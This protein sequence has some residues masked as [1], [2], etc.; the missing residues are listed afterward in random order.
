MFKT[1]NSINALN[2]RY[3]TKQ[4]DTSKKLSDEQL[5]YVKEAF[6]L[7]P[8]SYG[9]QA[10]KFV[11]VKDS[12][13]RAALKEAAFG[14]G[15]IEDASELFVLCVPTN[16]SI[17]GVDKYIASMADT[18]KM[19]VEELEGFR[20]MMAGN[21][22]SKSPEQINIWLK[23]QVY[24]ALGFVMAACAMEK[25]DTCPMEGFNPG[26]FDEILDL[27]SQ[28]LT[29]VLCLPVGFRAADDKY[30]AMPKVRFSQDELFLEV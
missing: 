6:R 21:L 1:N 24:I 16:Y 14:Q 23:N 28:S 3:A 19:K 25:I 18:R 4:F 13:K 7:A 5:A 10:W 9:L 26:K 22:G 17:D 27:G 20:D 8:S 15:Q 30:A 12:T 11:H 29:S 2:W